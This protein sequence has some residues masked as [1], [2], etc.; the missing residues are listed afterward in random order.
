MKKTI[1]F[2]SLLLLL[3]CS[4]GNLDYVKHKAGK[5]WESQGFE[6]IDYEGYKW[7]FWGFN[8]YGGAEVWYRLRK[9]PDNGITYS[10]MIQRWGNEL[11]V[12]GPNALD[13]IRPNNL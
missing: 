10:G 13:A 6:V 8:S 4:S 7:G 3:G 9:I 12:Y 2:L 11:H 5:K 1:I